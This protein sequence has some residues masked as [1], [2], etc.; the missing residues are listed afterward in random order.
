MLIG[1]K[2]VGFMFF[3]FFKMHFWKFVCTGKYEEKLENLGISWINSFR[4]YLV[5]F[6]STHLK[7]PL[8]SLLSYWRSEVDENYLIFLNI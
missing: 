7:N 3:I 1:R 4:L 2:P 6:G 5:P 8:D